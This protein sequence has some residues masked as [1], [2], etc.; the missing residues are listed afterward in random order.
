MISC[1]RLE[2][3]ATAAVLEVCATASNAL[4]MSNVGFHQYKIDFD[5]STLPPRPLQRADLDLL[6]TAFFLKT[7]LRI[8][9]H[10]QAL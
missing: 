10:F 7:P 8:T 2:M 4:T 3:V 9:K 1:N 6:L 5:P